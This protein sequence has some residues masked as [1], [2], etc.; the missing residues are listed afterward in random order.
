MVKVV[1]GIVV[2]NERLLLAPANMRAVA[3]VCHAAWG[4]R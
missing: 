2:R 3:E 1:A 4:S